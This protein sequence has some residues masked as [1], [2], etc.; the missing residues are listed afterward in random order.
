MLNFSIFKSEAKKK[1][2]LLLVE[3]LKVIWVP[4]ILRLLIN[5]FYFRANLVGKGMNLSDLNSTL[6]FPDRFLGKS[7]ITI[8]FSVRSLD[9]LENTSSVYRRDLEYTVCILHIGM[10]PH[11]PLRSTKKWGVLGMTLNCIWCCGSNLR[12]LG[13]VHY[14]HI[15]TKLIHES[16]LRDQTMPNIIMLVFV[17]SNYCESLKVNFLEYRTV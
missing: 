17:V 5:I 6:T 14:L 15:G 1:N 16:W 3:L 4:G 11:S 12:D 2:T 7:T 13:S 9:V 8:L 10:I